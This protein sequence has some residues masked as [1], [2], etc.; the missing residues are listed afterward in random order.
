MVYLNQAGNQPRE[1]D[2][3][4]VGSLCLCHL[5]I[6]LGVLYVKEL[7]GKFIKDGM[8][9]TYVTGALCLVAVPVLM[10]S[11]EWDDHDRSSKHWQET[12]QKII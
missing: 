3:A 10:A 11:Q 8:T 6:G 1:R 7:F 4:F 9:A 2:Y 12:W 5:W